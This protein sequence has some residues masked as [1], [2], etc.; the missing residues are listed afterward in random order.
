MSH[1]EIEANQDALIENIA[2]KSVL[3]IVSAGSICSSFIKTL[4]PFRPAVLVVADTNKN[5][6]AKLMRDLRSTKGMLPC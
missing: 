3:V 4:L 6:L 2:G 1:S 5:P